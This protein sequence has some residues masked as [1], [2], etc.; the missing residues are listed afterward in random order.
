MIEKLGTLVK[1]II[2]YQQLLQHSPLVLLVFF[3]FLR[4]TNT[5]FLEF[6]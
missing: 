5:R 4:S 6:L 1:E 2:S 3:F